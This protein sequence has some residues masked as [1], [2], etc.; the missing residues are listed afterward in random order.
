ML[1]ENTRSEGTIER[2][3]TLDIGKT[4]QVCRARVPHRSKP[5]WRRQEAP[6][7]SV[8]TRS[9]LARPDS[10]CSAPCGTGARIKNCPRW[11]GGR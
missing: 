2:V 1:W 11:V 8:M 3:A 4:D 5:G 6:T 7:H 9:V 10:R